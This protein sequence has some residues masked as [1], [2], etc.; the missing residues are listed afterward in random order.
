MRFSP[1]F[2]E[3]AWGYLG[4]PYCT[5][6]NS[7]LFVTKTFSQATTSH[8]YKHDNSIICRSNII[9]YCVFTDK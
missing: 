3:D 6:F 9:D 7:Y 5:N 4:V 8:K 2:I 1:W